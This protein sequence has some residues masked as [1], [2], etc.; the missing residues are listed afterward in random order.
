MQG[1]GCYTVATMLPQRRRGVQ[2][3]VMSCTLLRSFLPNDDDIAATQQ[4]NSQSFILIT[5]AAIPVSGEQQH[6]YHLLKGL[7][8]VE[9]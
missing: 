4:P 8:S 2:Q 9:L 7:P 1:S 3:L 6:V 5:S